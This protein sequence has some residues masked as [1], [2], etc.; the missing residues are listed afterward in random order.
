MIMVN[1]LAEQAAN[2]AGSAELNRAAETGS[3]QHACLRRLPSQGLGWSAVAMP[4]RIT[5]CDA[6]LQSFTARNG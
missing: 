1:G 4:P 6:A 5:I 3:A 2:G